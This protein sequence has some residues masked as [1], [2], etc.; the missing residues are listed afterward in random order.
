MQNDNGEMKIIE[1]SNRISELKHHILDML[2]DHDEVPCHNDTTRHWTHSVQY[3]S[4]EGDKSVVNFFTSKGNIVKVDIFSI[5]R[6]GPVYSRVLSSHKY[7][8]LQRAMHLF[9]A[10]ACCY[11]YFVKGRQ[12]TIIDI[13]SHKIRR[14]R[15]WYNEFYCAPLQPP[16]PI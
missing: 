8:E 7:A 1:N 4:E 10:E 11:V 16:A 9:N 6:D 15:A 2:K 5:R 12:D 3:L 13:G 14:N